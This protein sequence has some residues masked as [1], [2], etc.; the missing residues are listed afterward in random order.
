MT[1]DKKNKSLE[2]HEIEV[3]FRLDE[4]LLNDWKS[5]IID[6]RKEHPDEFDQ[7]IYVDSDDYY[8]VNP[9]KQEG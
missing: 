1:E 6:Y 5:T 9:N 7:F 2:F 8:Y 4:K 3:K